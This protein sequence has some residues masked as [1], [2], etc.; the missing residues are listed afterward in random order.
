MAV[1]GRGEGGIEDEILR[2]LLY[3]GNACVYA[4]GKFTQVW[5]NN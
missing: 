3:I 5:G 2:Y 1:V 4:G